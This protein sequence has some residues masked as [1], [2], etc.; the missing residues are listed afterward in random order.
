MVLDDPSG[1]SVSLLTELMPLGSLR[2]MLDRARAVIVTDPATQQRLCTN[3]VDGMACLHAKGMHH[4]D[5]KGDNLLL[6]YDAT[7]GHGQ[8]IVRPTPTTTTDPY[9]PT[10]DADG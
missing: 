6:S 2:Q 7:S 5:L 1:G 4:R 3:L 9:P 8:R 10:A